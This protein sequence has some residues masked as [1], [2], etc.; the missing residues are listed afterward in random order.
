MLVVN[1]GEV[2]VIKAFVGLPTLDTSGAEFKFG[3]IVRPGHRGI[4]QEPLR[5]GKYPINPRVYAAEIVPTSILTLNWADATSRGPQ[6]RRPAGADR[7][8]EPR[9]L[10]VHDRPA[11]ADPR[12][13]HEGAEGDLDGRHDAE[14]RQ[15]GAAVGGRQP[16]PQHAAGRSRRSRSSRPASEV[17]RAAFEAITRVP[18]PATRWRPGASTSRTS[19]SR[20]ARRGA[21]PARDRQPG[22]GDVRGAAAGRDRAHRDGEGQ[23]HRRHAGRSSPAAQVSVRHQAERG[24]GPRAGG[25][26]RGGLRRSSPVRPRP[27]GRQAI[28]LAE[29]KATEALGLARAAGFE[30]QTRGARRGRRRPLVAVA[31]A[32]AEGHIT[33][34]PEVLVTGGGGASTAS[35]RR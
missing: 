2:A 33:V 23:G 5:T 22:E 4:W 21:D 17:Q 30:A 14:P 26:G 35:R 19:C 31:N 10:R 6:P 32:V 8:Q 15:R 12:A 27:T 24:R 7:G 1:Q 34:V 13:R 29:A 28:G 25:R 3:S 20:G 16:L 11:G 9:G 18:R